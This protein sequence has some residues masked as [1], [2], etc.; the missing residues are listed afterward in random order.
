MLNPFNV[1]NFN[2]T[3][4]TITAI[5]LIII[6]ATLTPYNN[7]VIDFGRTTTGRILLS[8]FLVA[9]VLIEGDKPMVSILL[10]LAI[11]QIFIYSEIG[12]YKNGESFLSHNP[13]VAKH[14]DAEH[15]DVNESNES[16]PN[17]DAL[18]GGANTTIVDNEEKAEP[19]AHNS[20][21]SHAEYM[22]AFDGVSANSD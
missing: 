12:T 13:F 4:K 21:D 20:C 7:T 17:S 10:G 18:Y 19:I 2:D 16:M 15:A 5:V 9:V 3:L 6:I 1:F 22:G 14:S 8:V 11:I